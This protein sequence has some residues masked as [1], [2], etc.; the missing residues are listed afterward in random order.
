MTAH[1]QERPDTP[2]GHLAGWAASLC[3]H[4]MLL[5]G[6]AALL[7]HV[8]LAPQEKPFTWDVAMVRPPDQQA[9]QPPVPEPTPSRPSPA[10]TTPPPTRQATPTPVPQPIVQ[11]PT[12][13]APPLPASHPPIPQKLTPP[14]PVEEP[15]RTEVVKIPTPPP[16]VQTQPTPPAPVHP[17]APQV[18]V[19][20]PEPIP[21]PSPAAA[22]PE[23]AQE[24]PRTQSP[25]AARAELPPQH[26]P[27]HE[28]PVPPPPQ[29]TPT[30]EPP[31]PV[32]HAP[33]A[34][35]VV[36]SATLIPAQAPVT[37]QKE[38]ASAPTAVAALAPPAQPKAAKPDEGWLAELMARWIQ[39]LDKHYPAALRID[40]V[41]GKVVLIAVLHEDGTLSDVRIA[42]SSGNP[43]LDQA[44]LSDVEHGPP[45][46]LSHPLGRPQRP[47]KFSISYDLKMAR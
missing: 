37:D 3:F 19:P 29:A 17:P 33:T 5:F 38:P 25:T 28:P 6:A 15:T 43:L 22:K 16:I 1:A 27:V 31:A 30:P 44:A 26:Q 23:P 2:R 47:V 36:Q 7:Q 9:A 8:A 41:Q 12:L 20:H 39:D 34:E 4:G 45:I 11:Q 18:V 40:G 24:T 10:P 14:T 35:S 42:K 21:A 32:H 46:K 13:I